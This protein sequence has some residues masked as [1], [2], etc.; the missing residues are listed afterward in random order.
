MT[1]DAGLAR[2]LSALR[3]ELTAARREPPSPAA[4]REAGGE[5]RTEPRPADDA[6]EERE[7]SEQL[8]DL[9]KLIKELA[10]EAEQGLSEHPTASVIGALILGILIGRLLGKR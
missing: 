8:R 5:T 2:E 1:A 9:V 7:A 4:A 10:Q 6:G 3:D